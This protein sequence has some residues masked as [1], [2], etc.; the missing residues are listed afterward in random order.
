M[1]E[2]TEEPYDGPVATALVA[3][4]LAE[5]NLRYADVETFDDAARAAGDTDYLAE[6]TSDHLRRPHG[7]FVVGWL[8]EQPVA[9]GAVKRFEPYD[10]TDPLPGHGEIKR[11]F[12]VPAARRKGMSRLI[13]ARLEELALELGYT[14]L[15][16]ETGS[17]QPEAMALYLAAGW[18]PI[19]PYGHY[20]GEPT[21]R[22]F[23]KDLAAP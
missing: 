23:A 21:S 7:C 2:L 1:I 8:D 3:Q 10:R 16:L 5:L 14:S 15:R 4:L 17:P 20:R 13:L 6:V 19:E 9:C 22:C 11:M 18:Q 12:T